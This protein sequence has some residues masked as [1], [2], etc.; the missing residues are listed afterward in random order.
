MAFI[1]RVTCRRVSS[2]QTIWRLGSSYST[3]EDNEF[4]TEMLEGENKG[5][6]VINVISQIESIYYIIYCRSVCVYLQQT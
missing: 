2:L 3:A 6:T 5:N 4:R 1:T